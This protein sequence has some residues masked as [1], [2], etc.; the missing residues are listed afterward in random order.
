MSD[1]LY[2]AGTQG[3]IAIDFER[4]IVVNPPR[5]YKGQ[6]TRAV[7]TMGSMAYILDTPEQLA[8]LG[9]DPAKLKTAKK[10]KK[11]KKPPTVVSSGRSFKWGRR[12]KAE[13]ENAPTGEA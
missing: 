13:P 7:C 6:A 9:V 4:G 3:T 12:A 11:A 10:G 8:L 5:D 1:Y 2:L